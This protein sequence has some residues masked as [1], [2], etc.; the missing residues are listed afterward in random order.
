MAQFWASRAEYNSATD[1]YEIK[2]MFQH[3]QRNAE[4]MKIQ[5]SIGVMPPDE[6]HPYVDNSVS[7]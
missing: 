5:I 1:Q 4:I 2:G 3:S 6:D 7:L